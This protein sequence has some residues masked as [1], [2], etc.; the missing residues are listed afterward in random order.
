GPREILDGR[1]SLLPAGA[2]PGGFGASPPPG[3]QFTGPTR[4]PEPALRDQPRRYDAP[5][6]GQSLEAG[7]DRLQQAPPIDPREGIDLHGGSKFH[8]FPQS[9]AAGWP[10]TGHAGRR[11]RLSAH[12]R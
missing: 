10:D 12:R 5:P 4:S 8:S 2:P 11:R 7:D 3:H 6:Y 1:P 9:E